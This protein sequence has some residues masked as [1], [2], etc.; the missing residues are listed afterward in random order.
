MKFTLPTSQVENA[1]ATTARLAAGR[2]HS[3]SRFSRFHSAFFAPSGM[4]L[5]TA[6]FSRIPLSSA[7]LGENH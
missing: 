1:G 3:T 7:P 6:R 4:R 5:W 2:W